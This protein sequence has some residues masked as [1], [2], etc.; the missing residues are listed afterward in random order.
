MDPEHNALGH[1]VRPR[2]VAPRWYG[3][4]E[5][6]YAMLLG[7]LKADPRCE[8]EV[9][10]RRDDLVFTFGKVTRIE[11]LHHHFTDAEDEDDRLLERMAS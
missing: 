10:E 4:S 3:I 5:T 9:E 8:V 1:F 7:R 11:V 2:L 6:D